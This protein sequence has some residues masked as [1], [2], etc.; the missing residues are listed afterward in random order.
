MGHLTLSKVLQVR[1]N[2]KKD[3]VLVYNQ[4]IEKFENVATKLYQILRKKEMAEQTV[5]T[6]KETITPIDSIIEQMTYIE[7]L[8][9]QIISLQTAVNEA[10]EE[11][12]LKQLLLTESHKEVK[13]F[14]KLIENRLL[15]EKN[16]QMKL[17]MAAMDEISIQQFIS[18]N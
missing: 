2:E 5:E 4:A 3:A 18:K 8:N 17:D 12:E 11:M 10:R 9:Q 16:A 6:Y 15:A 14:E 1:E 7:S 13:K